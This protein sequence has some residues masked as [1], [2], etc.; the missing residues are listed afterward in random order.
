MPATKVYQCISTI[1]PE[2]GV[3]NG[4]LAA[5]VNGTN[6]RLSQSGL[7]AADIKN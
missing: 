2:F 6:I 5:H 7:L 1:V 4:V 3:L